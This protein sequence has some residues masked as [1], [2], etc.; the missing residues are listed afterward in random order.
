VIYIITIDEKPY[1]LHLTKRTVQLEMHIIVENAL[2]NYMGSEMIAVTQKIIQIIGLVNT[3]C[4]FKKCCDY[5][6]CKLKGSVK[7]G[8]GPCCTAECE[9]CENKTCNKVHLMGYNCNATTKCK[10]NGICNN[11]GN[12]HC[13]P[14]YRPP[15]CK[16]QIG[17]PGGSI[18]DGNVKKSDN[19]V[20]I[21]KG[22]NIQ[23]NNWLILSF[24]IALPFFII[25]TIMIIKR[26]EMRKSC[27]REN[28]EYEG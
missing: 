26:N 6:T 1:T 10:G 16:F 2:Y 5:N 20:F 12:C 4:Q 7:C 13:F 11:L 25:F 19:I 27:S 17:S 3:E 22:Y 14:G 9:Y 24:Y 28:T 21:K 8:S 15:D 18:D 23:R